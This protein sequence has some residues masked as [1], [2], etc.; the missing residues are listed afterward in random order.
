MSGGFSDLIDKG[1]NAGTSFLQKKRDLSATAKA[2]AANLSLI[3][4]LDWE[5]MY[6]SDTIPAYQKT[7]SPVA[8]SFIESYL[9]GNNPAAISSTAPNAKFQKAQ[10]QRAQ[11]Q[12]FGPMQER[13]AAQRAAEASN[14]YKVTTPTRKVVGSQAQSAE[15]TAANSPYAQRGVNK[16]LFDTLNELGV[17]MPES[18]GNE[19]KGG[20]G[21]LLAPSAAEQLAKDYGSPDAAAAALKQD[22]G[23][24]AKYGLKPRKR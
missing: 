15:W 21:A 19:L 17:T 7:K 2:R 18:R 6:S 23:L 4:E 14:P 22:P 11:D 3:K 10:Q 8:G 16:N 12:M 20:I 9:A 5:P 13:I 1:F 24:L